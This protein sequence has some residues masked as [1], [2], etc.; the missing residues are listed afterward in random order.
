MLIPLPA[1]E[2]E[3]L[4]E[5][6]ELKLLDSGRDPA[7]DDLVGLAAQW[8]EVPMAAVTLIDAERQYLKSEI[9]LGVREAPRQHSFCTHAI[10]NPQQLMVVPDTLAD[11][12][13]AKHPL[14]LGPPQLR[15]YA[16]APLLSSSGVA[17]GALCVLDTRPRELSEAQRHALLVLARQIC[18]L[19]E[20]HRRQRQLEQQRGYL[21][22]VID[23]LHEGL[24]IRDAQGRLSLVNASASALLGE[25]LEQWL[26][27]IPTGLSPRLLGAAGETL[28]LSEWPDEQTLHSGADGT[29]KLCRV[30][31]R[32]ASELTLEINTRA[33]WRDGRIDGVVSSLRDVTERVQMLQ[34]LRESESRL[35][36]ITD[37]VPA[38]IAYVDRD[39]RITFCNRAALQWLERP[40]E[41]V[42]GRLMVEAYAPA[43]YADRALHVR[44][45]L[46]GQRQDFGLWAELRGQAHFV[47]TSYVPDFDEQGQVRGFFALASDLTSM[48]TLEMQLAA[49]ARFDA[50]TGLPNRKEFNQQL[51]RALLR[52]R[53]HGAPL[54]V[55]FLDVD[56][57]KQ[58]NDR[59]GHA[60]GDLVLK[61]I[62]ARL[63]KNVRQTDFV[64]RL[65][66][67]EFTLV[68]E[69]LHDGAELARIADKLLA[70]TRAPFVLVTGAIQVSVS[71]GLSLS[72]AQ[73]SADTLLLRADTAMYAAKA[74]GRDRY[75]IDP[76]SP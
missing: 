54:A 51:G 20:L 55:G 60:A 62:A 11:A 8:C 70:A 5:L 33:L 49:E 31:R 71:M 65:A 52:S 3:R 4:T 29:G 14:V 44:A 57:F 25:P 75:L 2:S 58:I 28:P 18:A 61:E 67:D 9:G 32:D 43:S 21:R 46:A 10:L 35:Q 37:N 42:T 1:D 23:S 63:R 68:L 56:E 50:L 48:K 13:F 30:Q 12:R 47:Q 39:E 59:H 7:Y 19:I 69:D 34:R 53:R 76:D 41:L 40:P 73:D 26:G 74:A 72:R 15:F 38:L 22:T 66:G 45:A 64:A 36:S 6:H 24:T 17:L 16:G 27:S